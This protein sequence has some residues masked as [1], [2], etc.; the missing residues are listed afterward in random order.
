M[1]T[2]YCQVATDNYKRWGRKSVANKS[3]HAITVSVSG[4]QMDLRDVSFYVKKKQGFPSVTDLGVADIFLGGTGFS[5]KMKLS[6]AD[7]S[8]KQNFFKVDK[9]DVDVKNFNIKLKQSKHKLLFALAKP[10]MLKVI[11]P[12]LQ[13][14]LEKQIKD[15]FHQLDTLAYQVKVEADRAAQDVK[16][17]PEEAQNIYQRYVNAAQKQLLQGK[18]KAQNAASDKK[19]NVAMTKQDSIFPNIHLPGGISS[20]ATEYKEL[21]LKGNTWESPIFKLGSA[22][23]SSDIAAAPT[24]TRKDHSVTKGGVRGPQNIGNTDSA[25]NQLND[26]AAQSAG[27]NS[28]NVSGFTNQVDNAFSGEGTPV[29]ALNG[30]TNGNGYTNGATNGKTTF[31]ENNP[32]MTGRL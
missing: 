4:I 14:V 11:R 20:K 9:V 24:V 32:V 25:T 21:A 3:H 6:S 28:N 13:K 5:F 31:G 23:T 12:A 19:V 15:Q 29:A 22:S 2:S 1:L 10:I 16:D 8:D 18:Q 26:P 17:N 30:K 27:T 7:K